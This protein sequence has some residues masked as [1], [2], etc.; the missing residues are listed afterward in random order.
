MRTEGK[1]WRKNCCIFSRLCSCLVFFILLASVL[2]CQTFFK[3]KTVIPHD[4]S[5]YKAG[6]FSGTM[7][8]VQK[9]KKHYFSGDIFISR[10]NAL[11]M[12]VYASLGIPVFTML[13]DKNNIIVL[14][15][16]RKE[17][18]KGHDIKAVFPDFFP[19]NFSPSLFK[20]VFFDRKPT[21]K[22]WTCRTDKENLPV[23]CRD[24]VWVI[25]W[26]RGKKRS[27]SLKSTDFHFTFQ[28]SLF[29]FPVDDNLFS[30]KISQDF[31]PVFLLK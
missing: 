22:A 17:F 25:K 5:S 20:E 10:E 3:K 21:G 11:R 31:K 15:L 16:R 2:S 18:Y 28:Y 13:W 23:E 30:V 27:L 29:S 7:S 24:P 1:N 14:F 19:E 9:K 6:G 4:L 12:D 26:E 8:I